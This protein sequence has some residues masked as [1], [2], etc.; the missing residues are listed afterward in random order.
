[1]TR[2]NGANERIKHSEGK[3]LL[4]VQDVARLDG[5]SEKTVR[6]AIEAGLLSAIRVGPGNRLLRISQAAHLAYRHR[7]LV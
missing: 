2:T 4:T 3:V 5:V 6:R 1:M 7:G